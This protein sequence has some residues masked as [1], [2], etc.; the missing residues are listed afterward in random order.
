M[1]TWHAAALRPRKTRR[2]DRPK[3]GPARG[4][5]PSWGAAKAKPMDA[6]E[7]P[8]RESGPGAEGRGSRR[9]LFRRDQNRGGCQPE[10]PR[11]HR[12]ETPMVWTRIEPPGPA[13]EKTV[14][15]SPGGSR[16]TRRRRQGLRG[17][18]SRPQG[19]GCA[20]PNAPR[21]RSRDKAADRV[22]NGPEPQGEKSV[23]GPPGKSYRCRKGSRRPE[24]EVGL[25]G[26]LSEAIR[27]GVRALPGTAWS[28][29]CEDPAEGSRKMPG[30]ARVRRPIRGARESHKLSRVKRTRPPGAHPL[31]APDLRRRPGG[32]V[33]GQTGRG[34]CLPSIRR[35]PTAR[36]PV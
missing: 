29:G 35:A 34:R 36:P 14:L 27:T 4:K 17:R 8:S 15:L 32:A 13:R 12:R 19:Q 28:C 3:A 31:E 11:S 33:R 9:R 30:P 20:L 1:H 26:A 25:S 24:P 5:A 6:P 16:V 18:C 10:Q 23:E 22:D 2:S 7:A 21:G